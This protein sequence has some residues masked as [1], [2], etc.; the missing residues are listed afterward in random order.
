MRIGLLEIVADLHADTARD[1]AAQQFLQAIAAAL[2]QELE[3]IAVDQVEKVDS[4]LIFIRSGGTEG[5][6]KSVYQQ[7]PEPYL[8]LTTGHDNSLAASLEILTFLQQKGKEAEILHGDTQ[9]IAQRIMDVAR[10]QQAQRRLSGQR[11]GV[12]G[13]PS[14]WLIASDV[15]PDC[16]WEQWGLT[17]V[18]I[19]M[20]K[21]VQEIEQVEE[22]N[23]PPIASLQQVEHSVAIGAWRIYLGLK[24]LVA[25]YDLQAL[26]VRC[27][28]LL[29]QYQNTGCLAVALLNDEGIVAG[30]E[31]DVP[32]LLSM[33]IMHALTD[34]P[35][36][37]ANPS[38]I[39]VQRNEV[40]L[41]HCTVPLSMTEAY[42]FDTHF[43]S[44]LGIGVRGSLREGAV[45]SLSW[46]V[47]VVPSL[48]L[49]AIYALT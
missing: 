29:G 11:I 14:D 47:I 5:L 6:F 21:L 9:S 46:A 7:L 38:A 36:F 48:F 34:E 12:I 17:L 4:P 43:E 15:D 30:C 8:L 33:V 16:A 26:T 31:G 1:E 10:M 24:A 20:T 28:D 44:G 25:K 40:V 18:P 23:V 37:L 22:V 2:G 39:D 27:F 41:A 32:A 3:T 19:A 13:R 35:V 49:A 42:S 45:P